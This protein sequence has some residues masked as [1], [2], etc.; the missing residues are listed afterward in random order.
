M[1]DLLD[2]KD[3]SAQDQGSDE[4]E[5]SMD[6]EV[7]ES[8][9]EIENEIERENSLN[10]PPEELEKIFKI[11]GPNLDIRSLNRYL[12]DEYNRYGETFKI[13]LSNENDLNYFWR[14]NLNLSID[15]SI[16][17][18]P[19][20]FYRDQNIFLKV[21][22][23]KLQG[24]ITKPET[25][26]YLVD[27]IKFNTTLKELDLSHNS[28]HG[29]PLDYKWSVLLADG[30]IF[31]K[32]ITSLD[33]SHSYIGGFGVTNLEQIFIKN[34]T[35]ESLNLSAT[36]S[37]GF[38]TLV[39][40]NVIQLKN[41]SL[42]TLDLSFNN[43]GDGHI[44]KFALALQNNTSLTSLNM[45]NNQL[46]LEGLTSLAKAL[47]INK[48]L[49]YLNLDNAIQFFNDAE[50]TRAA[51]NIILSLLRKNTSIVLSLKGHVLYNRRIGDSYSRTLKEMFG[52]R[53][54]IDDV[55]FEGLNYFQ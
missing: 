17:F 51:A 6:Q 10:F 11:I 36:E 3:E 27:Q 26:R 12:Y 46:R 8:E 42:R 47:E 29:R 48:T 33:L 45:A 16:D 39:M 7:E 38:L 32:S 21:T 50:Q 37:G 34:N 28:D 24:K 20:Y 5:D 54:I 25:M 31:N 4:W 13:Y 35:L 40:A 49:K 44:E 1:I 23:L 55:L 52:D 9:S 19:R 14:M 41:L 53:I 30:M 43:I 18:M 22:S 15:V 2:S